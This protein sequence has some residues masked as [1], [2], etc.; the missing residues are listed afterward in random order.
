MGESESEFLAGGRRKHF[1]GLITNAEPLCKSLAWT[2]RRAAR[3]LH[4]DRD[5][6]L[7]DGAGRVVH[8]VVARLPF[9]QVDRMCV[10][11]SM[12]PSLAHELPAAICYSDRSEGIT[13]YGT[14]RRFTE[15]DNK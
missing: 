3:S 13:A 5:F 1:R 9:I 14:I 10:R 15:N 8:D 7:T 2:P 6:R 4:F 12:P 11:G